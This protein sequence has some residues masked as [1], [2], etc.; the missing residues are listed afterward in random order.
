MNTDPGQLVA[1]FVAAFKTKDTG[2]LAPFLHPEVEFENYGDQPS[3]GREALL[4]MW[5]SVF[6]TFERVEF[7]TLHQ[8]VNKD[9]VIAEQIHGLGLPGRALAPIRNV[10]IYR[11]RDGLITEWRDYTNPQ[12]AQTLL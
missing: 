4:A 11:V 10:A 9:L 3:H 8:A 12:H 2:R 6:D 1:G 5:N 7:S